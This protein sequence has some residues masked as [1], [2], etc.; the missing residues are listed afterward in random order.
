VRRF[1]LDKEKPRRVRAGLY[2]RDPKS[3]GLGEHPDDAANDL[4]GDI[5]QIDWPVAQVQRWGTRA[6]TST[7]TGI[8]EITG[9]ARGPPEFA[10]KRSK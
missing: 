10:K 4:G 2:G 3:F 8:S 7:T 9:K 1:T 5:A 6:S